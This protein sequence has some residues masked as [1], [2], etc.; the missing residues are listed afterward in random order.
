MPLRYDSFLQG[1]GGDAGEGG[2]DPDFSSVVLLAPFD[3]TDGKT[4]SSDLS[5]SGHS[6]VFA[7]AFTPPSA[8]Y[9][10]S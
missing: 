8:A 5:N 3:G 7:G 1:G 2:S 6:L 10:T 4:S 9:P